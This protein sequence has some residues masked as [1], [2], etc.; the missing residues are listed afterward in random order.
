MANN[1]FEDKY[2]LI[3]TNMQLT[4]KIRSA[5]IYC[6]ITTSWNSALFPENQL[7]IF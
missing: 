4:D 6:K 3:L 5:W 7:N 1:C 2:K